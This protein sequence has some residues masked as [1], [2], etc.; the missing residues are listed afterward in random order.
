MQ[1]LWLTILLIFGNGLCTLCIG[2][3]GHKTLCS[4]IFKY[5]LH[6]AYVG[7]TPLVV[8]VK[9]FFKTWQKSLLD[10]GN[11]ESQLYS[12]PFRQAAT[13]MYQPKSNFYY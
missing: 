6:C 10:P 12:L 5:I 3:F 8:D 1:S 2:R 11:K 7:L 13:S 9:V 4:E